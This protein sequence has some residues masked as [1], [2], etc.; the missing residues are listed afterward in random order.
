MYNAEII[1]EE[2][3]FNLKMLDGHLSVLDYI[4]VVICYEEDHNCHVDNN[5]F[6]QDFLRFI[7]RFGGE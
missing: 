6:H 2:Y 7:P 4:K 1:E 5:Q 3:L